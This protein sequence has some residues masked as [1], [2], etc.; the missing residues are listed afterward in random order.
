MY[1]PLH[2]GPPSCSCCSIRALTDLLN[3]PLIFALLHHKLYTYYYWKNIT[4]RIIAM[5]ATC[6]WCSKEI[7]GTVKRCSRC[8]YVC[9]PNR[10]F[11]SPPTKFC[12]TE[13]NR[14]T[15]YCVRDHV[16]QCTASFPDIT[17]LLSLNHVR[18]HPGRPAIDRIAAHTTRLRTACRRRVARS[19][20]RLNWTRY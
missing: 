9:T 13:T 10:Q 1:R 2:H 12:T 8:R 19:G 6:Y 18:P 3:Y 4:T 17:L 11:T 7:I 15:T 20:M 16:I 14:L 5:K